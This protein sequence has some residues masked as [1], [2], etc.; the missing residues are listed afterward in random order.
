MDSPSDLYGGNPHMAPSRSRDSACPFGECDGSGFVLREDSSDADADVAVPCRCRAQRVARARTSRLASQIP[1]K[2]R[3]VAFDRHPVTKM[4]PLFVRSVR[5]FCEGLDEH[6][7]AGDS[8]GFFGDRGTGKTTLA[9]L[10]TI[11]AMRRGRTVAVYTGPD[12]LTAIRAT[13]ED[14]SYMSL[15]ESLVAVD[16]LHIEDLSVARPNE[17]V[18]EQLYTV[19]NSR[20]QDERTVVFTADVKVPSELGDHIGE[21]S[22]SRL[23]EMCGE[24]LIGV[25][26][27]DKRTLGPQQVAHVAQDPFA[28]GSQSEIADA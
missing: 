25:F 26:G 21:R 6:L 22:V 9:M 8:F 24:R 12:L 10:I 20:Y 13:Y 1:K 7:D 23:E 14:N 16:L 2:Y 11:E 5:R 4:E 19:I 28:V 3:G 27:E 15:M 18:L 17:W